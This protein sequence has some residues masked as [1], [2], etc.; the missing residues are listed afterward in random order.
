MFGSSILNSDKTINRKALGRLVFLDKDRLDE[1]NRLCHPSIQSIWRNEIV[2]AEQE[3]RHIV[4]AV[5]LL[6]EINV[7]DDF[8]FVVVVGCPYQTQLK[9]LMGRGFEENEARIRINAQWPNEKKMNQ[10][11]FVIW[12]NGSQARALKQAEAILR[13]VIDQPPREKPRW[14][15]SHPDKLQR[16]VGRNLC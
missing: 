10:G 9:R 4:V 15:T 12:T 1:L 16:N 13:Y 7:W 6:F 11:D 3:G 14:M 8:D 5:P 2:K